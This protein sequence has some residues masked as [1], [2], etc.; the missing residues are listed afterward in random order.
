MSEEKGATAIIQ[1][2]L[3]FPK[4]VLGAVTGEQ[5]RERSSHQQW[6]VSPAGLALLSRTHS[7]HLYGSFRERT[8]FILAHN[9]FHRT[10]L[11]S[12]QLLRKMTAASQGETDETLIATRDR[13]FGGN[14]GN[15]VIAGPRK[16]IF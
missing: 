11:L 4:F 10:P 13:L 12:K 7:G 2:V 14:S 6:C 8:L 15:S 5:D 9:C 16:I 3:S 1:K